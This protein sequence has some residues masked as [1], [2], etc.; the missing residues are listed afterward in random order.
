MLMCAVGRTK[1][2]NED[3][4]KGQQRKLCNAVGTSIK[5]EQFRGFDGLKLDQKLV[6]VFYTAAYI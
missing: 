4:E 1:H 3:R 5:D 6:F 2:W